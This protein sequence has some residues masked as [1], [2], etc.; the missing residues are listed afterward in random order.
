MH[1]LYNDKSNSNKSNQSMISLKIHSERFS[2]FLEKFRYSKLKVGS[3]VTEGPL[4]VM[5]IT[6]FAKL[7]YFSC[8]EMQS[9]FDNKEFWILYN[10]LKISI[11]LT[12][13]NNPFKFLKVICN[14]WFAKYWKKWPFR[15]D[16]N[17]NY[18]CNIKQTKHCI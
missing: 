1:P 11:F 7:L 2:D 17:D 3:R 4:A 18:F 12:N 6:V 13:M 16:L 14:A 15:K 8:F 9:I 10:T 5:S